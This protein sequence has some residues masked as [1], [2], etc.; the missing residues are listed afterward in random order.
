VS[1]LLE[2]VEEVARLAGAEGLRRFRKAGLTVDTK[3]DGSPVTEADREAERL[4]RAWIEARFPEDGIVG[5]EWGTVRPDA[6]RVWYLDPIDGTKAFVR[7]VPLW[8][9]MVGV[10]EA[11]ELVAG[12]VHYPALDELVVAE[13]GRG[14]F[15]NGARARV[16]AVSRLSEAT[17]LCTDVKVLPAAVER[18]LRRGQ[19]SRTWGDCYGYLLVATGRAEVMV[20]AVM[21]PWDSAA[22]LPIIEEAGGVFTDLQ[23]VR[24]GLG[25]SSVATNAALSKEVRGL[26]ASA[27]ATAL[28][29][30]FSAT[31]P[32]A[33][34]VA[35]DA[36]TGQVLMV[37]HADAEALAKTVETGEMHYR[38]RTRG[39]WHKGGTS[40]NTQKVLSLHLDCDG[41]AVL[42][43]V[44]PAGP[45]CHTLDPTCF[46]D[47]PA[48]EELGHLDR[49]ISERA[50]APPG[51]GSYT[52]KLLGNRNLRLKKV[53]E[54][55]TE[56]VMALADRDLARAAEEAADVFYH[57]LVALRAEGLGLDDVRAVLAA[58]ARPGQA[59]ALPVERSSPMATKAEQFKSAEQRKKAPVAKKAVKPSRA[60]RT[61]AAA[62]E[63]AK[64]TAPPPKRLKGSE[65]AQQMKSATAASRHGRRG[66]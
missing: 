32:M 55:A 53:G 17:V 34:V 2:A 14:C 38:S 15:W 18:V 22:L 31:A 52:Q 41:D 10:A 65:H 26:L 19:V 66:G 54:E 23:G 36:R 63:A 30:A 48:A 28:S 59:V 37:A 40:G 25:A 44:L 20:D 4:A 24:T 7:G 1:G 3:A 33:T 45:A 64:K 27:P 51:S 56:L 58:R 46:H 16:S 61:A 13:R 35:Q 43:R 11:G 8:G 9:A 47:A 62:V 21:N 6:R 60:E 49:T 42:A 12:C 39:L 50:A 29:G 57:V 5:E